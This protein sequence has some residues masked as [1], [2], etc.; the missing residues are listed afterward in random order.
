MSAAAEDEDISSGDD[1]DA[2]NAPD[3]DNDQYDLETPDEKRMRLAKQYL[4]SIQQTDSDDEGAASA[5]SNKLIA[6]RLKR[7]GKLHRSLQAGFASLNLRDLT[8]RHSGGGHAG[9][10]T[11]VAL[12]GDSQHIYTGG[13]DNAVVCWNTETGQREVL[14]PAW[15][16][17]RDMASSAAGEVLAV[18]VSP[19]GRFAAS[20]GRDC[21]IHVYDRRAAKAEVHTLS[22]HSGAVTGLA[23]QQTGSS[24]ALFSSSVDRTVKHWD[25]VAM[26]YVETLFGHQDAVNAIACA[27]DPR[28]LTASA[29]RSVRTWKID[30]GSHLVFRK[31]SGP[32]D[33]VAW[34]NQGE[35]RFLSGGQDGKLQ[36][37]AE[38]ARAPLATV[39][40]AHG[41]DTAGSTPRWISSLAAVRESDCCASGSNDGHVRVWGDSLQP[42]LA[43]PVDG[44][45]NGLAVTSELMVVA[46]GREHRLGRWWAMSKA[47]GGR[48]RL[49]VIRFGRY[50]SA[51]LPRAQM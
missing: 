10:L 42:L 49:T 36:L 39:S 6:D 28:P 24:C 20:G 16:R 37:W 34:L 50:I 32:V 45:A 1:E 17:N 19:D 46:C 5:V 3:S 35:G 25:V 2:A 29:D 18:A 15:D 4:S 44:F 31:H 26:S 8:H 33:C 43:V 48:D 27:A 11:C 47:E 14:R 38:R 30:T 51:A 21:G 22:G 7:E 41:M 12:S 23:F 40:A 9:S 13:K